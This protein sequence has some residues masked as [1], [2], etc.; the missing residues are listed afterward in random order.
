MLVF[1]LCIIYTTKISSV[2]SHLPSAHLYLFSL[3]IFLHLLIVFFDFYVMGQN[4]NKFSLDVLLIFI[5]NML[6]NTLA[7]KIGF[8]VKKVGIL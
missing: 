7:E 1:C 6:S 2:L 5:Y 4:Y 8:I 3:G